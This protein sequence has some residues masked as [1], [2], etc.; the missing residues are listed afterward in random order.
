MINKL[1]AKQ[2]KDLIGRIKS[3][4][5]KLLYRKKKED[6]YKERIEVQPELDKKNDR[7]QFEE[8]IRSE[9]NTDYINEL[10][11]EELLD[12]L[13]SNPELIYNIPIEKIGNIVNYY[14]ES[15][16]KLEEKLV[17]IKQSS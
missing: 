8:S 1:P 13:D 6:N 2:E 14:K 11:R 17:K 10:K 7:V 5:Q 15:I 16:K 12:K 3:F 4:F 9:T